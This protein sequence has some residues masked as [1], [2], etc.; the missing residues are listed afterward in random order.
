MKHLRVHI[1]LLLLFWSS[2]AAGQTGALA[3]TAFAGQPYFSLRDT[4]PVTA[5]IYNNKAAFRALKTGLTFAAVGYGVG[6]GLVYLSEGRGKNCDLGCTIAYAVV[7]LV[8]GSASML[9]ATT[10][11]YTRHKQW[12]KVPVHSRY[13]N[14]PFKH[15][16]LSLQ[17]SATTRDY[18]SAEIWQ[19]GLVYRNL[20]RKHYLPT[21][22]TVLAG[23]SN[24]WLD[25]KN[26]DGYQSYW[27]ED[28]FAGIELVYANF[29][30]P[31][32]PLYGI[33]S[34]VH[35]LNYKMEGR[36][37]KNNWAADIDLILGLHIQLFSFLSS[38]LR[39]VYQPYGVYEQLQPADTKKTSATRKI[40]A[41]FQFYLF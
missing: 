13:K 27:T 40:E 38:E 36:Q 11:D 35:H 25:Y 2:L 24:Y 6:F 19:L 29:R 3:D 30:Q 16:G 33:A 7:P 26:T 12:Q 5:V 22:I 37:D 21:R 15:L 17:L 31:F 32:S 34:R 1:F 28:V 23:G 41:G 18:W 20:N 9:L 14:R 39:W 10:I 4:V 8:T